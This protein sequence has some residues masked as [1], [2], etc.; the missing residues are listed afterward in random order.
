MHD[1]CREIEDWRHTLSLFLSLFLS[2]SLSLSLLHTHSLTVSL[3]TAHSQPSTVF[4]CLS[5]LVETCL[6]ACWRARARA[7]A[8][9]G[10]SRVLT[11]ARALFFQALVIANL[12]PEASSVHESLCTLR[13]DP[14]TFA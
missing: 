13:S 4:G 9:V 2:L 6:Y 1:E 12:A 3:Y 8:L 7:R 5:P 10:A 11:R 14:V